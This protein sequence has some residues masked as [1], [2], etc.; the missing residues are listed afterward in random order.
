MIAVILVIH[1]MLAVALV[2]TVLL[3]R[4]EGGGLGIGGG[5]GMSGLMTGRATANLL[6]RATAILAALFML[7]SITL[8]IFAGQGRKPTSILQEAAP[9]SA[10]AV[11]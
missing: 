9:V 3:Q 4:S 2:A 6:T 1:I 10:P 7:T 5:G 8:A 11:P